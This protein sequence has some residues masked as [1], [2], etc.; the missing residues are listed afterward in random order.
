MTTYVGH[1]QDI[2]AVTI[3]PDNTMIISGSEDGTVRVW[4]I[5][6]GE[7]LLTLNCSD[8]VSSVAI[9]PDGQYLAAGLLDDTVAIF[10]INGPLIRKLG[11]DRY[12]VS[13]TLDGQALITAGPDKTIRLWNHLTGEVLRTFSGHQVAFVL[14]R[15][16][17]NDQC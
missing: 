1:E 6:N 3:S 16:R 11:G 8:A 9:T 12:R 17:L 15:P 7:S 4:G 5:A 14:L 10:S 13:F 2:W